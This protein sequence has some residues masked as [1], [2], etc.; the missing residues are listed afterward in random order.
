MRLMGKWKQ[1][2]LSQAFKGVHIDDFTLLKVTV[3]S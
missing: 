3:K 1:T 2:I